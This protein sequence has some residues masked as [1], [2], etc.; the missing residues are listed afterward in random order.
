MEE[1]NVSP[2]ELK[3][4]VENGKFIGE[5]Y[6]G[7]VITY[8]CRLLKLDRK[9]FYKLKESS[10]N[11]SN[12]VVEEYYADDIKDFQDRNQIEELVKKQKD[13]TLTKLPEGIVTLKDVSSRINGISPGIII[14]HHLG[15]EKLEK[16]DPK[17][18]T[19]V[20]TILK[21]LLI[22][23]K[24]LADNKISQEDIIQYNEFDIIQR[25][26]NIL[27]KNDTPQI[28]DM[29]GFFVKVGDKFRNAENM[30]R[31]LSNVILDY[32]YLNG[33]SSSF[34]REKATTYEENEEILK[35]LERQFEYHDRN[36]KI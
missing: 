32:F 22:A 14:P 29:S 34:Y 33:L 15:H 16:L 11:R 26:L 28:I 9:L 23:I 10:I 25:Q 36:K 27:Y 17:E 8:Q 4:I 20:L 13:I 2:K 12:Y 3:E 18:H 6:Y 5:G 31:D 35:E 24:E 1:V 30:Y 7:S 19:R 21:K